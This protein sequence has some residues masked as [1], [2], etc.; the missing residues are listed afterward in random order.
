MVIFNSY[1]KL[2]EGNPSHG[3]GP[4]PSQDFGDGTGAWRLQADALTGLSLELRGTRF[5]GTKESPMWQF[6]NGVRCLG[7]LGFFGVKIYDF[8]SRN[9]DYIP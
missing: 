8:T 5:V 2:P 6:P 3:H 4:W 7:F 1:V 9:G